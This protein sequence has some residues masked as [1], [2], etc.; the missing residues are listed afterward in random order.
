MHV[1]THLDIALYNFRA[2]VLE[3]NDIWYKDDG[4]LTV[5]F[6]EESKDKLWITQ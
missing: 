3:Y 5:V 4:A 1:C 6:C 2:T